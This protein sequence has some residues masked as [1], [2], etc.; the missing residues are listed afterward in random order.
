MVRPMHRR[1]A[2]PPLVSPREQPFIDAQPSTVLESNIVYLGQS[3]LGS[4]VP[5]NNQLR[6]A[7]RPV[8]RDLVRVAALAAAKVWFEVDPPPPGNP[9]TCPIRT[10]CQNWPYCGCDLVERYRKS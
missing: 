2:F 10:D 7:V 6:F 3:A 1:C 8:L 4:E 5:M 9:G